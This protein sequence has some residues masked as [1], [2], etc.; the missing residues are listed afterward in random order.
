MKKIIGLSLGVLITAQLFAQKKVKPGL[1]KTTTS[2]TSSIVP[3]EVQGAWMYGNFSLTEYWTT[4]PSTYLGNALTFAIAFKFNADGTYQHYFTSSVNNYGTSTYHQSITKGK[5]SV[6]ETAK[7][8]TLLPSASH[9]K[10]T[11]M[12]RTEEDR[13][14]RKDELSK[15]NVYTYTSGTEPNGTKALSLTIQGTKSELKFQKKTL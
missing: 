7:I 15:G 6:D 11:N 2:I 4:S 8:I 9:Y 3:A 14:M 13:D 10:R 12:S 1:A 5:F